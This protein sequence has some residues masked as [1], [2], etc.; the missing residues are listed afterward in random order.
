MKKI[1]LIGL[2]LFLPLSVSA[3]KRMSDE[4]ESLVQSVC[5]LR[6]ADE[7]TYQAV[8]ERF[9]NDR[10]WTP[11]NETGSHKDGE[12]HPYDQVPG[13]KLNRL[14]TLVA[15]DRKYVSVH[16]DML[17]GEDKRFHYSLYER[18]VHAG[19]TVCYELRGRVGCQWFVIVP[20]SMDS[21]ALSATVT[22][23]G[24]APQ[25][26]TDAGNGVKAVYLESPE[27]TREQIV[28][29]TVSGGAVDQAFVLLNH[30][31]GN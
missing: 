17:N 9:V 25:P 18:S 12:C 3:Q 2:V 21:S 28:T 19:K 22:L 13:F 7:K 8:R 24:Q 14:L 15:G 6:N 30:N 4:L 31:I 10:E 27:L 11:M 1:W 5:E 23:P 16:G 26:F 29:I 20:F